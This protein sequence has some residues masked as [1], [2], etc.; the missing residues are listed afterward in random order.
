MTPEQAQY[1]IGFIGDG[2]Y[3]ANH[4][5]VVDTLENEVKPREISV[6]VAYQKV[7]AIIKALENA[8]KP[9]QT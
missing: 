8:Q 5:F 1:L 9:K 7:G 3:L 6:E 2:R 4:I